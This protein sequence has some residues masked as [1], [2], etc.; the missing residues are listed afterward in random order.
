MEKSCIGKDLAIANLV[1]LLRIQKH[2]YLN[3][4][5]VIQGMLQLNKADR[6]LGYIKEVTREIQRTGTVM[7]LADPVLVALLL[8]Y[9]RQ[10][11]EKEIKTTVMAETD[12]RQPGI[13]SD[14]L[15]Q[16]VEVTWNSFI[17]MLAEGTESKSLSLSIKEDDKNYVFDYCLSF[18]GLSLAM[19]KEGI[20][21]VKSL[22]SS[23]GCDFSVEI[24]GESCR[25]TV[26]LPRKPG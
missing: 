15:Y 7:R 19:V 4:L 20:D 8:S 22:V 3:Q 10:A 21:P 9:V 1:K 2:D 6:A 24:K 23:T 5:Q 16:L 11:M 18:S 25:I 12:M 13:P 26:E 14:A 17:R